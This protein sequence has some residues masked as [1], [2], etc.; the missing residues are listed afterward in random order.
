[1]VQIY[2]CTQV[3]VLP[4]ED[5][6]SIS[7]PTLGNTRAPHH[8]LRSCGTEKPTEAEKAFQGE[9]E[10]RRVRLHNLERL[11]KVFE[12]P[13][14]FWDESIERFQWIHGYITIIIR[15]KTLDI[16]EKS[17]PCSTLCKV[18][19]LCANKNYTRILFWFMMNYFGWF[20]NA[21]VLSI[22]LFPFQPFGLEIIWICN[23]IF[24][25]N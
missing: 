11:E 4:L 6:S 20:Q 18:D 13:W 8:E 15:K 9:D 5:V 2:T 25:K 3:R 12:N 1:M 17:P 7:F 24:Q 23:Q 16:A 22:S 14:Q 10:T 19:V 21:W